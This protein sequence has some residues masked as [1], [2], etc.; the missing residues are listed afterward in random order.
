MYLGYL[1]RGMLG[2]GSRLYHEEGN[3]TGTEVVALMASTGGAGV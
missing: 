3:G 2:T 1:R